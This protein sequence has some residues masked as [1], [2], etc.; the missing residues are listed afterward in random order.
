MSQRVSVTVTETIHVAR[1]P[2]EVFDYTQDYYHRTDWD[3]AITEAQ[4]VNGDPRTVYLAA[5]QL[6]RYT[7]VY[8]L[9]RRPE[10][11]S[12]AFEDMTSTWVSG[13]GGSWRYEASGAGTHWT[14]TNTLELKHGRLGKLLAPLFERALRTSM[15]KSMAKAKEIMEANQGPTGAA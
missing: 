12:A 10:R 11:T 6:G 9:F 7:L 5:R 4:V 15:R 3:D 8:R 13:G 14:Q 1:P 2:E